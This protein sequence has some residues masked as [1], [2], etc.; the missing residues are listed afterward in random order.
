MILETFGSIIKEEK[1]ITVKEGITPNTL[2]LENQVPFPGYYGASPTDKVPD[3]FFLILVQKESTEKIMRL[4]HI[5]RNNSHID[6]DGSPVKICVYNDNYFGIRIR[7]LSD[8]SQLEELQNYYRDNG[9][10]FMKKKNIDTEGV[11][12]VKKI[13]K[14]REVDEE[15]LKDDEGMYYLKVNKQVIWSNFRAITRKVKNNI[16][17]A[18]FDA[19]L[20]IIYG[21]EVLDLVR[22]YSKDIPIEHLKQIHNKYKEMIEKI[23]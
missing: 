23:L 22:I 2:V 13:F 8:F 7:N 4:T 5:I 17:L 19:A 9:L 3:S 15:T 11:I 14:L 21:S 16:D 10:S 18:S 20:S 1:L 12:E 6:F